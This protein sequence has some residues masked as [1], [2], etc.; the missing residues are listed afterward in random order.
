MRSFVLCVTLAV[1][2]CGDDGTDG[3]DTNS[4]DSGGN[5]LEGLASL[6][7]TPADQTLTVSVGN[8]A[9]STYSAQGT[10]TDGRTEDV[11]A[12]VQWTVA[13]GT[14]A[15]FTG[16]E[17][18]TVDSRG[19][20]TMVGATA[21][22]FSAATGLTVRFE[23]AHTDPGS[24]D[25]PADPGPLFDGTDDPGRAPA[26]VYPNDNVVVPPNL[27][28]LE[29]H[30]RPGANNTLFALSF[31]N[32]TIDLTVYLRCTQPL[33]G[34]CI[35]LPDPQVWSWLAGTGRGADPITWS[36]RGT[37]DAGTAVG[38]SGPMHLAFAPD[39]LD[40]GIYYWTTTLQAIMRY[41]FGSAT[42]TEA[43]RFIGTEA[44]DGTCMGCHAL[45]R[46]GT[47]MVAEAGGQ[48]DGRIVLIDV[49]TK[50]PLVPFGSTEKSNFESW[51]QDGSAFAGVYADRNA[52]NF[53]LMI[54]DGNT[55]ELL[56]TVD[57]GGTA[58]NPTNHPDWSP[59]EDRIAYVNVGIHNTLQMGYY[60]E[61]RSVAKTGGAWGTPIVLAPRTPGRNRYYPTYAPD[62]KLLVFNESICN[63]GNQ[64]GECNNDTDPTAKLYALDG[65]IE[66]GPITE[67]AQANAPGI[68]DNGRTTLANSFPKW[69]PFVF[70]RDNS[71]GRLA[72]VTFSSTRQYG[73]RSP[74]GGGTLLWMAAVDL[75]APAGTDPSR[76]AFA[77]PFQ[78]LTT[79]NHIAQ[80]TTAI[81]PPVGKR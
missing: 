66:N 42:Q 33:N 49:A 12:L 56:E 10:F 24:S 55:A 46:D 41:D 22:G 35:Y 50:Q 25:V 79:S 70:R 5:P 73:L 69:N 78:D 26:L 38:A 32:S 67:L 57:V 52:T 8:P 4:P 15:S 11:S 7:I 30:F 14:L 43:E 27:G 18:A 45:S 6:T 59:T 28:R 23:Q 2:G 31:Q 48:N 44:T 40:G 37:D 9:R 19:G 68:A 51:N 65:T 17:L 54:F 36:I 77:L 39:D 72:W 20:V 3:M 76:A 13:D 80:W 1:L 34:G 61:I 16:A 53:N 29:L 47:K 75:D 74:P 58:T 64:G 81:P 71:G 62:G 63:N 60:G 21:G